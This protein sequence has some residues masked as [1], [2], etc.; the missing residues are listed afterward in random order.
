MIIYDIEFWGELCSGYLKKIANY[1][2][3][4]PFGEDEENDFYCYFIHRDGGQ[5]SDLH[6]KIIVLPPISELGE[7]E[8]EN[9]Y[10]NHKEIFRH[11]G[12]EI[13]SLFSGRKKLS[14]VIDIFIKHS[15]HGE[16][17]SE[18][19]NKILTI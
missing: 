6:E 12:N 13:E 7:T 17:I 2:S 18:Y 19:L 1:F 14:E 5:L 15:S 9:V 3:R 16:K 4:I 11:C 8:L 10:Y